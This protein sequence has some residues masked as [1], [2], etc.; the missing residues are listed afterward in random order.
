MK[1]I[2]D[3][4]LLLLIMLMLSIVSCKKKVVEKEGIIRDSN[5]NKSVL[6]LDH[7]YTVINGLESMDSISMLRDTIYKVNCD[8]SFDGINDIEL[9]YRIEISK[10][11]DS[12]KLLSYLR[13]INNEIEFIFEN[14]VYDSSFLLPLYK[15]NN[16][17]GPNDLLWKFQNFQRNYFLQITTGQNCQVNNS[18]KICFMKNEGNFTTPYLG[19]EGFYYVGFR[20][21]NSLDKSKWNYGYFTLGYNYYNLTIYEVVVELNPDKPISTQRP[22]K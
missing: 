15:I 7:N 17:I 13:R 19:F 2:L 6:Y 12:V 9:A 16:F 10:D 14:D 1:N 8:L 11:Q 5:I 18:P 3:V 4:K 20:F 22:F 21:H